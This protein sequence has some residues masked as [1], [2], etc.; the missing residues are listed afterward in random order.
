LSYSDSN[1]IGVDF[2]S[3][4]NLRKQDAH[5]MGQRDKEFLLWRFE[6][7]PLDSCELYVINSRTSGVLQGYIFYKINAEGN[8]II[9]D[10]LASDNGDNLLGLFSLFCQKMREAG[11]KS[12]SV[13]FFGEESVI[14]IIKK[15]GFKFRD[16]QPII[17]V[18]K[19]EKPVSHCPGDWYITSADRD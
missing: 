1:Q 4:W 19:S 13:E 14:N 9:M 5:C 16:A 6:N 11:Y 15:S 8:V 17:C 7:N 10:F 2:D 18:S 3:L 12:V